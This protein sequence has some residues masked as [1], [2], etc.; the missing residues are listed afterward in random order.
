MI[1]ERFIEM[2]DQ[3]AAITAVE[4]TD[5]AKATINFMQRFGELIVKECMHLAATNPDNPVQ[6]IADRYGIEK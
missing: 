1:H 3:A 2:W 4:D 6:A 5:E